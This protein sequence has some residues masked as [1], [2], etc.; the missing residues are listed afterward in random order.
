MLDK[1]K[2][3]SIVVE[4]D[5]AI[6]II[7]ETGF[8]QVHKSFEALTDAVKANSVGEAMQKQ[9]AA[10]NEFVEAVKEISLSKTDNE[11]ITNV[12]SVSEAIL[13]EQQSINDNIKKLIEEQSRLKTWEFSYKRGYNQLTESVTAKQIK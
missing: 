4:D 2:R 5:E 11:L 6:Q 7:T 10:I 9:T 8:K 13:Q 3:E 12:S 1:L